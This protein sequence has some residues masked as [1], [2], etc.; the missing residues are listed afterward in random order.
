MQPVATPKQSTTLDHSK[1]QQSLQDRNEQDTSQTA[2]SKKP[3]SEP[4]SASELP[5]VQQPPQNSSRNHQNSIVLI[6]DSMIKNI[7]PEKMTQRKVYKYTY[8][9]KTADQIASEVE[10]I[11]LPETPSHVIIHAG[12]NDLSRDSSNDCIVSIEN[13]CSSAQNKFVNAKIRVSSIIV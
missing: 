6:G 2:R 13:V 10:N 12:T 3:H 7:I 9:G 4:S 5:K 8:S 1:A 11:N